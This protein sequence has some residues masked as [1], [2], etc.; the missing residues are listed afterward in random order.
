MRLPADQ[1]RRE[2][3]IREV[4]DQCL[5]SLPARRARYQEL[6]KWV[7]YGSSG[8]IAA[9]F[10]KI[11]PTLDQLTAFTFA[12]ESTRFALELS[13]D[14][15]S[16][17]KSGFDDEPERCDILS[18]AIRETWHDGHGDRSFTEAVF[19]AFAYGCTAIKQAWIEGEARYYMVEPGMLGVLRE[20]VPMLDDQEAIAQP[21]CIGKDQLRRVLLAGGHAE[22]E[23]DKFMLEVPTV[24]GDKSAPEEENFVGRLV[25]SQSQPT[26]TG[27]I[28]DL[29]NWSSSLTPEI[30]EDLVEM[31]ELWLWDDDLDEYRVVTLAGN[32]HIIFDREGSSM[33][34]KGEQ[35]FTLVC[36]EPIYN[37]I[38]G[39]SQAES[40]IPLQMWREDRMRQIDGL[41]QRQL[42]PPMVMSGFMGM[43]EEK[44]AALF[45]PMGTISDQNQN[46]SVKP[47]TPQ[48]PPDPFAELREIDMMFE[49]TVGLPPVTQGRGEPGVRAGDQATEMS[50]MPAARMRKRALQVESALER[51]GTLTFKLLQRESRRVYHTEAGTAFVAGQFPQ[52]YAV[53]VAAHTSSPL[54]SGDLKQDAEMMFKEGLIDGATLLELLDPPMVQVLQ[55]RLRQREKKQAQQQQEE[56]AML[57]D[58]LQKLGPPEKASILEKLLSG[59]R[60]KK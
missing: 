29:Q 52:E 33:F 48:M 38:W 27:A 39:K 50:R 37:Y 15:S 32:H 18:A 1:Q 28:A 26:M 7:L 56:V 58:A 60:G 11:W 44:A 16:E 6:R 3:R 51:I 57:K 4:L 12:A 22:E 23:V 35:P 20:D 13:E 42:K 31:H 5:V 40:L 55:S 30:R 46:A 43:T 45:R 8:T 53:T 25:I 36:P 34:N 41:W 17:N 24:S 10:N 21:Y 9:K 2:E 47:L 14:E 59:V 54:F 19:W 49:Y